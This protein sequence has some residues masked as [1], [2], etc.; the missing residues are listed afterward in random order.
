MVG[1]VKDFRK[2][3]IAPFRDQ[4]Y[5]GVYTAPIAPADRDIYIASLYGINLSD[6]PAWR[7]NIRVSL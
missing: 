7:H 2:D 3:H 5:I 4:K 6:D 1:R